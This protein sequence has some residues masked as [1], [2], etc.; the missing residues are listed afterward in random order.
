MPRI[1]QVLHDPAPRGR[2]AAPGDFGSGAG[3]QA[4]SQASGAIAEASNVILETEMNARVSRA[5]AGATEEIDNL[6]IKIESDPAYEGAEATFDKGRQEILNRFQKDLA[7]GK[8]KGDF[9]T[10]ITP[11]AERARVAVAQNVMQ[12]R[13]NTA[14]AIGLEAHAKLVDQASKAADPDIRAAKLQESIRVIDDLVEQGAVSPLV[15]ARA[16]ITSRRLL[17][18]ADL[19]TES[20]KAANT[21]EGDHPGDLEAQIEASR[22]TKMR[23]GVIKTFQ[24]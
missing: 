14:A 5:L 3:L 17:E 16:K 9:E 21:I 18:S 6:R 2:R 20:R 23:L 13:L 19:L 7:F 10:R 24:M 15:G 11:H 4:Y 8:Y 22:T 12:R 1:P